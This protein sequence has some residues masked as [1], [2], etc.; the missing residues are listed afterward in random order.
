MDRFGP[1]KMML[2]GVPLIAVGFYLLSRVADISAFTGWD[3][4]ILFYTIYVLGITLGS[5]LGTGMAANT[6]VA[7]W[8]I[9][10]RGMALGILSAGVGIGAG[11]WVP[12]IG[13]VLAQHF[14]GAGLCLCGL[15]GAYC[16][17][18]RRLR[19]AAPS[20]RLRLPA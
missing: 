4:L 7:N 13:M 9:R 16:W 6:A 14:L 20:G 10:R 15:P 12:V 17:H 5:S 2:L 19:D 18:T 1:R 11:L 3:A 8:F